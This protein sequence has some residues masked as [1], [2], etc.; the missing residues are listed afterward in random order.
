MSWS[1]DWLPSIHELLEVITSAKILVKIENCSL[2]YLGL[3]QFRR[4]TTGMYGETPMVA[5]RVFRCLE[6]ENYVVFPSNLPDVAST[7]N[8]IPTLGM[9]YF[10]TTNKLDLSQS[11]FSY[12][13]N[14]LQSCS[15]SS[16]EPV[17]SSSNFPN[18]LSFIST[19]LSQTPVPQGTDVSMTPSFFDSYD[20]SNYNSTMETNQKDEAALLRFEVEELKDIVRTLQQR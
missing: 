8:S 19:D 20:L 3:H 1:D 13:C 14:P 11:S 9:P 12:D 4:P 17:V 16:I 15:D 2:L 5:H 18:P 6:C 10:E 7:C